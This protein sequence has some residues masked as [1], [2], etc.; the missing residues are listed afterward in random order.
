MVKENGQI[1]F[2]ELLKTDDGVLRGLL[3]AKGL[4]EIEAAGIVDRFIFEIRHA[5]QESGICPIAGLGTFR[6][7][8]EG[9]ITFDATKP[10]VAAIPIRERQTV[11]YPQPQPQRVATVQ[12]VKPHAPQGATN[13]SAALPHRRTATP[14]PGAK[15]S[16]GFIMWFAGI[17]IAGALLALGYGIYC[18][19]TAPDK[20]LDA[21]MD[22]QRIPMIEVPTTS[23]K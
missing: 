13:P 3:V 11:S 18:M 20:D 14:R 12:P 6:R 23:D 5:L 19:V 10:A 17:V 1:L 2:S 9:I 4:R 15:R 8:A 21:Q 22:A 7:D 16:G